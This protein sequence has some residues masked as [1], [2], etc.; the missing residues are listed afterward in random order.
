MTFIGV[1]SMTTDERGR[2]F[3]VYA[4]QIRK[5]PKFDVLSLPELG[6]WLVLRSEAELR[7]GHALI[8][9][10]DAILVLRRR[11]VSRPAPLLDALL[12]IHLLDVQADGTITVHDR[13]DHDRPHY[14]SDD[15][16]EVKKRVAK[17]RESVRN[18]SSND[19][20]TNSNESLARGEAEA[21]AEAA[22]ASQP[23]DLRLLEEENGNDLKDGADAYFAV[24]GRFPSD[25]VL[26]WINRLTKL[27]GDDLFGRVLAKVYIEDSDPRT[28]LSRTEERLKALNYRKHR[29]E[30]NEAVHQ[31]NAERVAEVKRQHAREWEPCG[32]CGIRRGAHSGDHEWVAA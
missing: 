26:E 24:T 14:P 10:D 31:E 19:D 4:R 8:D 17:H 18:E 2:W 22:P 13:E 30:V 12:T 29:A 15:P 9:R 25:R 27:Y 32:N 28:H 16:D 23:P 7:D 5:H 20:V 21:E 11:K 3:R 1:E 6:A